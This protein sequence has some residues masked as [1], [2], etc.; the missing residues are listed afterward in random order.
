MAKLVCP[1]WGASIQDFPCRSC[2]WPKKRQPAPPPLSVKT[3]AIACHR[4][5]ECQSCGYAIDEGYSGIISWAAYRCGC[6]NS[7]YYQ[8]KVSATDGCAY[9][10][11]KR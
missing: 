1:N 5:G 4:Q 2:G 10:Q 6:N 3:P 8:K 9:F 11:W 7:P